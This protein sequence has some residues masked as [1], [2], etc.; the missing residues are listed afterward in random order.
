MTTERMQTDFQGHQML[1]LDP[2]ASEHEDKHEGSSRVS[3]MDPITMVWQE[4]HEQS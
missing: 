2:L 4:R 1:R 3:H